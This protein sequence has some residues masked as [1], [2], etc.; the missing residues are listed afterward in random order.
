MDL[1]NTI[2][3]NTMSEEEQKEQEKKDPKE[4]E[5][6]IQDNLT[7]FSLIAHSNESRTGDFNSTNYNE[8]TVEILLP[9]PEHIG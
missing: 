6:I 5:K 9:P 7:D 8:Y 4:E 1:D 3:V 2:V